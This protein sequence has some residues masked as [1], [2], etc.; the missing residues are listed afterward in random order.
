MNEKRV[1]ARYR[2]DLLVEFEHLG[3]DET[4]KGKGKIVNM[5]LGGLYMISSNKVNQDKPVNLCFKLKSDTEGSGKEI[6]KNAGS[7]IRSGLLQDEKN[8]LKLKYSVTEESEKFYMAVKF[9][10]PQFEL[11]ALLGKIQQGEV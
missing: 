11:S 8:E 10:E 9:N 4:I 6:Y 1:F 3:K 7:I 2:T 5:S